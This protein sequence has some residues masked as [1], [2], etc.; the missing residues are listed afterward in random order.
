[1][2]RLRKIISFRS[3]A[4][5]SNSLCPYYCYFWDNR[6]YLQRRG[7]F[8]Q[9]VCIGA[10]VNIKASKNGSRVKIYYENNLKVYQVDINDSDSDW[11]KASLFLRCLYFWRSDLLITSFAVG[12]CSTETFHLHKLA[13]S[14]VALFFSPY[15]KLV[16]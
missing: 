5:I 4:F 8:N 15:K 13:V 9:V 11:I 2:L 14:C 12:L 10:V 6:K 7:I 3:K 1:M 16:R